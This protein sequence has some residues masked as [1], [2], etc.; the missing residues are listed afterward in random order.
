MLSQ[1]VQKAS[2]NT[3][4]I[5]HTVNTRPSRSCVIQ[6]YRYY[7]MSLSQYHGCCQ[8][9]KSMS[10]PWVFS[11]TISPC[12]YHGSMFKQW[13]HVYTM[14]PRPESRIQNSDSIPWV[15]VHTRSLCQIHASISI[16]WE[17][18]LTDLQKYKLQ[19]YRNT[20]YQIKE[21]Q[22]NN[23]NDRITEIQVNFELWVNLYY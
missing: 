2:K 6:E 5:P 4:K 8:Y 12:L 22:L 14:N 15:H 10:I 16:P 21:I 7:T 1:Y 3:K 17:I 19:H 20:K 18:Q 9:H 13:V 11:N 23:T